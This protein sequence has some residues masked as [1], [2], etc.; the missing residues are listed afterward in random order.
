MTMDYNQ[1]IIFLYF[2]LGIKLA[3]SG[4]HYTVQ[5]FDS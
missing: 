3:M 1:K 2:G 4:K 5:N